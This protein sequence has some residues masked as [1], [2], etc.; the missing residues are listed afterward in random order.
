MRAPWSRRPNSGWSTRKTGIDRPRGGQGELWFRT[1]Q[2]M[3]GYRNRPEAYRK[4]ITTDD[5]LHTGDIGHI[6][7]DGYLFVED[8]LKDMI[9]SGGENIYSLEVERAPWP[10]IRR[11]SKVAVFGVPDEKWGRRARRGRP[12]PRFGVVDHAAAELMGWCRDRLALPGS[13]PKDIDILAALPPSRPARSSSGT[14]AP[15]SGPAAPGSPSD[16]T[17]GVFREEEIRRNNTV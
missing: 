16:S 15:R 4:A 12:G 10:S 8:R 14:C 2:L 7:A 13:H 9:I 17:S 5:W 6:D 1:P 3:K 11:C